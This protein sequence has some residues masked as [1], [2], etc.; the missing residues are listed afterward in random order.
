MRATPATRPPAAL[1]WP[2]RT[3]SAS[4]PFSGRPFR[5]EQGHRRH[6]GAA[7]RHGE[8][9][10]HA[11]QQL[12][13]GAARASDPEQQLRARPRGRA[14]GRP[15]RWASAASATAS[16]TAASAT[17][18]TGRVDERRPAPAVRL[19][20]RSGQRRHLRLRLRRLQLPR[21]PRFD[22]GHGLPLQRRDRHLDAA[23]EHAERGARRLG[24]LLPD[25]EQDLRLRR[26]DPDSRPGHRLRR[27]ADLRHRDQHVDDGRSHA[28]SAQPDGVRLQ[29]RQR[30]DLP[31]R[32]LRDVHASTA[33]RTRPGS[34]TRSRTRGP[35]RHRARSARARPEPPPR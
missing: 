7:E 27:D 16:T 17:A 25:D 31:E 14:R 3:W 1:R 4:S 2:V 11:E 26:L 20:R 6:Q 22:A 10:H 9:E 34:T 33:S 23:G 21:G 19:R 15:G 24:R 30:Q 35:S 29:R 28:R 13:S 5:P 18:A 8:S 32:R 12:R